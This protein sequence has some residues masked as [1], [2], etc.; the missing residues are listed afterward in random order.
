MTLAKLSNRQVQIIRYV[1]RRDRFKSNF[2]C[3]QVRKN[4]AGV[5]AIVVSCNSIISLS[6][7]NILKLRAV[8]ALY[9][10]G[11]KTSS[12]VSDQQPR[13]SRSKQRAAKY[14]G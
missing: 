9:P 5:A 2:A 11:M 10:C 3:R 7:Q 1:C 12:T 14:R 6:R 4:V 8:M 13:L